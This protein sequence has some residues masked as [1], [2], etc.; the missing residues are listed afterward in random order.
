MSELVVIGGNEVN[1]YLDE[2]EPF[3]FTLDINNPDGTP[4]AD[5]TGRTIEMEFR[6]APGDATVL[7]RKDNG[8]AGGISH[9]GVDCTISVSFY[10]DD[11]LNAAWD[12][13]TYDLKVVGLLRIIQGAVFVDRQVTV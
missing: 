12:K 7:L 1:L 8:V 2:G 6:R 9:T 13:A 5:L 3:A 11:V 4:Y 10:D